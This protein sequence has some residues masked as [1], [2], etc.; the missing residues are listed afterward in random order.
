MKTNAKNQILVMLVVAGVSTGCCTWYRQAEQTCPT[1]ARRIYPACAG[2]EA[3]R[4]CPCGP[5]TMFYGHKPTCWGDWPQGWK[6]YQEDLC[7]PSCLS[8]DPSMSVQPVPAAAPRMAPSEPVEV[9]KSSP[10]P[11]PAPSLPTPSDAAG[12]PTTSAGDQLQTFGSNSVPVG[13]SLAAK[14]PPPPS[15]AR[16]RVSLPEPTLSPYY[17]WRRESHLRELAPRQIA[18]GQVFMTP[19]PP[20]EYREP[21]FIQPEPVQVVEAPVVV[22]EPEATEVPV[23]EPVVESKPQVALQQPELGPA[24][25]D[26]EFTAPR[27]AASRDSGQEQAPMMQAEAPLPLQHCNAMLPPSRLQSAAPNLVL[28]PIPVTA[29]TPQ[30]TNELVDFRAD[31]SDA[32]ILEP[33]PEMLKLSLDEFLWPPLVDVSDV[34]LVQTS[35][36]QL[37]YCDPLPPPDVELQVLDFLVFE[38]V[39]LKSMHGY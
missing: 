21:Q 23:E 33:V 36:S 17:A 26:R 18:A 6:Q 11:K 12:S 4:Q 1:D 14:I 20:V 2:E 16:R 7:G 38:P 24:W 34:R 39:R 29:P 28:M 10:G 32:A 27:I 31:Q 13:P 19:A 9:P 30:Q 35:A 15:A 5:D 37:R 8:C 22:S 3:V 25:T